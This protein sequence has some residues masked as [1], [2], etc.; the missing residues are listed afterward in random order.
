MHPFH[1]IGHSTRSI[2]EFTGL[3]DAAAVTRVVD[4]RAF[5]RSRT[6]P[7]F[8]EDALPA[9]IAPAGIDYVHVIELGGRRGRRPDAPSPNGFWSNKS[10]RNYADYALS[11][12]FAHG[13]ARLLALGRE[14]R[15]AMMCSEAVWWRCH[16]RLIA[17]YL[18]AAGEQVF[19]ILSVRRIELAS[20]T[21]GAVATGDGHLLYPAPAE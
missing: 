6:N 3:L 1:T 16:R 15:C 5:P 9:S 10:F 4:V 18:L 17:D 12:E 20:L 11:D 19:H 14:R 21:P 2:E 7:Q 13:L 8:N